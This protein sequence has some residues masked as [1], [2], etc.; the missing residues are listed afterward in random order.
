M[1][2]TWGRM[3]VVVIGWGGSS[4]DVSG[5]HLGM[6]DSMG[7]QSQPVVSTGH[8]RG[9]ELN[10]HHHHSTIVWWGLGRAHIVSGALY[11][12]PPLSVSAQA[13]PFLHKLTAY[14]CSSDHSFCGREGNVTWFMCKPMERGVPPYPAHWIIGKGSPFVC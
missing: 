2:A 11:P 4:S 7:W 1:W 12:S 5:R 9:C 13:R 10:S 6:D 14:Y 3:V 8:L